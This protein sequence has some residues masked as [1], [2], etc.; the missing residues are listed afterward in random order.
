[1][2]KFLLDEN[3]PLS[4]GLFLRD[5]GFDVVHAK[6]VEMLGASD[7]HKNRHFMSFPLSRLPK[8]ALQIL[9]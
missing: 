2:I 1:M 3:V 8:P 6:E 9:S 7:N 5:M 4:I